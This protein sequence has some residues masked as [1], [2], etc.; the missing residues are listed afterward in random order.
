MARLQIFGNLF[1]HPLRGP[2]QNVSHFRGTV[3][4]CQ[5]FAWVNV[6][7]TIE[8]RGHIKYLFI[9]KHYTSGN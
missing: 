6:N 2:R 7:R 8:C 1:A 3:V 5:S 9:E 4:G